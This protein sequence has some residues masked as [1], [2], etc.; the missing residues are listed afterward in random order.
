M[1][2]TTVCFLALIFILGYSLAYA[3]SAKWAEARQ[4]FNDK[5]CSIRADLRISAATQLSNAIYPAVEL[6]AAKLLSALIKSELGRLKND[7]SS[8]IQVSFPVIEASVTGLKKISQPKAVELLLKIAQDEKEPWRMRFHM[9]QSL[10]GAATPEVI[11]YAITLTD[12]SVI[13]LKLAALRLL[14]AAK[15]PDA[16]ER[17]TKLVTED[18]TWEVKLDAIRYLASLENKDLVEPL[19]NAMQDINLEGIVRLELSNL[20][21]QL[22]EVDMGLLGKPWLDWLKEKKASENPGPPPDPNL[23]I[24]IIPT[25]YYGITVTST[26]M[27][28]IIDISDSMGQRAFCDPEHFSKHDETEE[29]MKRV[30]TDP[31]APSSTEKTEPRKP[32]NPEQLNKLKE[33]KKKLDAKVVTNR[34]E[35]AGRELTN[36]VYNLDPNVEFGII[37]F[38]SG[39]HPWKDTLLLASI[40]NKIAVLEYMTQ[41]FS[42]GAGTAFYDAIEL[43]YHFIGKEK[44]PAVKSGYP[45]ANQPKE[46]VVQLEKDSNYL[47]SFGG[48]DVF[49]MV[50]DG[51]PTFGKLTDKESIIN[52]IKKIT[53]VRSVKIH[54][55][56]IGDPPIDPNN[57][58]QRLD[59]D[60]KFLTRLAESTGGVFTDKTTKKKTVEGQDKP[61]K[62]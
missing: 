37:F 27:I 12:S 13:P 3:N 50:T 23:T 62:K 9:M 6:D 47:N 44:K 48:A 19:I 25:V 61:E 35:A 18:L 42:M 43:A 49:F 17:A 30:L 53:Q 7:V 11:A 4:N 32:P 14:T 55:V 41:K 46:R 33:L 60:V 5:S 28:F 22:T 20:L 36:A 24:S 31:N 26:R 34:L 58:S 21:K 56:A 39:M 51:A 2:K 54:T 16:T 45:Q 1:K 40:D 29:T 8:E 59:V 10:V 57:I 15:S 38:D 52:E